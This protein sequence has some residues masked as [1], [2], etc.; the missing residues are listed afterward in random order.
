MRGAVQSLAADARAL[1]QL[2]ELEEAAAVPIERGG[3]LLTEWERKFIASVREQFDDRHR[4]SEAQRKKI[5][6]VSR[7]TRRGAPRSG[8][9]A[10]P[11]FSVA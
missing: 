3:A 10:P 9:R 8:T 6:E 7:T 4:L 1:E 5:A 11:T 2:T